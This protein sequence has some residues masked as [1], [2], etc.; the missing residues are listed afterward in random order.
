MLHSYKVDTRL[1]VQPISEIRKL[2]AALETNTPHQACHC[3]LLSD[4]IGRTLGAALTNHG[5]HASW[6]NETSVF[7]SQRQE[8]VSIPPREW[9]SV[10]HAT[11]IHLIVMLGFLDCV[12]ARPLAATHGRPPVILCQCTFHAQA[13]NVSRPPV[14]RWRDLSVRG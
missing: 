5:Q 6:P 4:L 14:R 2:P 1:N 7:L 10:H 9:C 3:S 12:P 8:C 11:R 13:M